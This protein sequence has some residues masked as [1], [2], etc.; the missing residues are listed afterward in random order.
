MLR[1]ARLR[2]F[3]APW[4]LAALAWACSVETAEAEWLK[5]Q[6][7]SFG[8]ISQLSET[9]TRAWAAEF[10]QFVGALHELYSVDEVPLP[11][12]TIVLFRS[13]REFAPYRL[14]TDSGQARIS[15]F[16]GNTGDWSVIGMPGNGRDAATRETIFHEAVHWFATGSGTPQP[17]WFAEGLAEVLSTFEVVDGSGRWGRAIEDHV[18]FL[19]DAGLMP[20][21]QMLRASQ[22]D[23]LHGEERDRFYPQAWA[24]VH[25]LMFGNGGADGAT[26]AAFLRELE[27]ANLDAAVQVAFG[28]SY[29]ELTS[30]LT[31]YLDG[32]RYGYAEVAIHDRSGEMTIEPA[33]DASVAFALGRLATVG[34]NLDLASAHAAEVIALAPL[35]PAGHE[36]SAYAAHEG[37]ELDAVAHALERAIE[38][39]SSE[40]WVYATKAD[41]LLAENQR[42]SGALDE[43]LP[44]ATARAAADLYERAL[45]LRPRNTAAFAGLA[46]AL[47]NVDA[48]SAAD[49]AALRSSRTMFPTEGLLLVGQAAAARSRG[50]TP[51]AVSLLLQATAEPFRMPRR[52]RNAVAALR[53]SWSGEWLLAERRE[54][55][56]LDAPEATA[57]SPQLR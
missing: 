9:E 8:V 13:A 34:G 2:S 27:V 42:A 47:L 24:F 28:K 29:D 38:L 43:L 30:D 17:L 44:A 4:L 5:L 48:I 3:G 54:L 40:S 10:E 35:S 21:E 33:S 55:E 18:A 23:A 11:P 12:L 14:R 39:G 7:P 45:L 57:A 31:R 6:A 15:A 20:M 1:I 51:A 32:G 50:D 49:D 22:D 25:A 53:G 37:G 56:R 26:L 41:R 36:L 16:F 52:Y 19:A 46:V